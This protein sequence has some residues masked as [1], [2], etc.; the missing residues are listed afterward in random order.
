MTC[1]WCPNQATE[2][3]RAPVGVSGLMYIAGC[4][5]HKNKIE[6][7]KYIPMKPADIEA[8]IKR[9]EKRNK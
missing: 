5:L 6:K 8:E 7:L 9:E 1:T 4:D 2:G 3:G